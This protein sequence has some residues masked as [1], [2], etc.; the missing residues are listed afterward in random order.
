MATSELLERTPREAVILAARLMVLG[1]EVRVVDAGIEQLSPRIVAREARW[2]H[3]DL[4]LFEAG[5]CHMAADPVPDARPLARLL[6][7]SWPDVP[8][9]LRGPL[10]DRYGAELLATF[11]QLGGVHTGTVG[12]WMVG[13]FDP[14]TAPGLLTR[15]GKQQPAAVGVIEDLPAWH[16]LPLTSYA[17]YGPRGAHVAT[18]GERGDDLEGLLREVRHAVQRAGA[19]HLVF[20]AR[21]L[22]ERRE[23]TVDL[24]RRMFGAAPGVP[25][26]CRVRADRLDPAFAVSLAQGGCSEVL[27]TSP[28]PSSAPGLPPMD[29]P[30]REVLEAALEAV[31]VTGM[32]ARA[33]FMVGRPGHRRSTLESWQRWFAVR[34]VSVRPNVR[35]L[36]AGD[37]G[38]G[39]PDLKTARSRAGCWDNELSAGDVEKAVKRLQRGVAL[40]AGT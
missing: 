29:D 36:H 17:G 7:A 15:D 22:G 14:D 25:W 24:T 18:I 5:G 3:A 4:V 12:T 11:P 33:E 32:T 28:A 2:W 6:K 40:G 39:S 19:G 31:R 13:G 16:L 34:G 20:E 30:H 26:S 9:L 38:A 10:G 8:L 37:Q 1:A 23:L 27:V 21:D 35:R